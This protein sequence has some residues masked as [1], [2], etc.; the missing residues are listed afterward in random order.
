M[1]SNTAEHPRWSKWRKNSLMDSVLMT[2]SSLELES[3]FPRPSLKFLRDMPAL[4]AL[5]GVARSCMLLMHSFYWKKSAEHGLSYTLLSPPL[6]RKSSDT[7]PYFRQ[8]VQKL[9]DSEYRP[10]KKLLEEL[11]VS[12]Q[13]LKYIHD[14][15]LQ[16]GTTIAC[17]EQQLLALLIKP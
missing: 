13:K 15:F 16:R 1:S 14:I 6:V 7:S 8:K 4:S 17:L 12:F 5:R 2:S 10:V 3:K 11:K 9:S